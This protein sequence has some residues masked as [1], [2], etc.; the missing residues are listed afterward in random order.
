M[1]LKFSNNLFLGF[2]ELSQLKESLKQE[3]YEKLLKQAI[4]SYGIAKPTS[5]S[6]FSALKVSSSGVG[7]LSIA[8]GIAIDSDLNIIDVVEDQVDALTVPGDGV[9][10]FVI[11]SYKTTLVE[12]GTVD[13]SAD[14]VVTGTDTEFTQRLRGQGNFPSKIVFVNADFDPD[15]DTPVEYEVQAVQNDTLASLN[16]AAG[17]IAPATGVRYAVVGSFTPGIVVPD[18]DKYPLILDGYTIELRLSSTLITDKE[19]LLADVNYNGVTLEINDRREENIYSFL[20]IELASITDVNPLIGI[21]NI[22]YDTINAVR[23]KNLV[24]LGWGLKSL[25]GNWTVNQGLQEVTITQ[26]SGGIWDDISQ[27]AAGQLDGWR[28]VF[29]E[30]GQTIKVEQSTIGASS[31]ILTLS[32]DPEYPSTGAICVVPNSDIVEIQISSVINPTANKELSF[33]A[34][35]GFAIIPCEAGVVNNIKYRH[36]KGDLTTPFRN[37]N[38]G[39]YLNEESFDATGTP[40]ATPVITTYVNGDIT[41]TLST[42]LNL[43]L[44]NKVLSPGFVIDFFGTLAQAEAQVGFVVCDGRLITDATSIFN[45]GNAPNLKGRVIVGHDPA[46]LD[47]NE[48]GNVGGSDKINLTVAQLAAHTHPGT[49]ENDGVH[50]HAIQDTMIPNVGSNQLTNI[51]NTPGSFGNAST[52]VDG[53]HQHAFTTDS[54]GD[55]ADIDIRQKYFVLHKLMKL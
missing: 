54:T 3:G 43:A 37:L 21:H 44:L 53:A 24:E 17:V 49:T 6:T 45:G 55:G 48:E 47:Y 20:D 39:D 4:T 5:T 7:Q 16:I 32:F 19:F 10:R 34:K 25:N 36:I 50:Q 30:T 40:N 51:D 9:T 41:P 28:V 38:D 2:A 33:S 1:D 12:Q 11:A 52:E 22:K 26:A 23:E 8:A 42:D 13:I 29:E 35:Q 15:V 27:F 14:G 46:A 31:I 18:A